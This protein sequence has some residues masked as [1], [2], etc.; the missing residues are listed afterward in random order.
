VPEYIR[1]VIITAEIDTN[2][3]T[4][5]Y[6]GSSVRELIEFLQTYDVATDVDAELEAA[7]E[8]KQEPGT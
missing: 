7:A 6:R 5:T 1:S 4:Y 3:S 2:K 8:K